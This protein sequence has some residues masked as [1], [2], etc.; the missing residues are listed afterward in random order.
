MI[1]PTDENSVYV[2]FEV[3]YGEQYQAV[4]EWAM[5]D[6]ADGIIA[7]YG[8]MEPERTDF[9]LD[10]GERM[11]YSGGISRIVD[12]HTILHEFFLTTVDA[13]VQG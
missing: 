10:S 13:P 12:E 2:C 3:K 8:V 7:D 5:K 6:S 1:F 11:N 9:Q 4:E